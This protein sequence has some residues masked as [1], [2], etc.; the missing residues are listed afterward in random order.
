MPTSSVTNRTLRDQIADVLRQAILFGEFAPGQ[1]LMESELAQ[2]FQVS[3]TPVRE[4]LNSLA[5]AGLVERHGRQGT[6]VR[7]LDISDVENLLSVRESLEV[8][9]VRQAAP[10]VTSE[11]ERRFA[12]ILRQQAEATEQVAANPEGSIPKLVALNDEFHELILVRSNN[13]WLGSMLT[14]IQDLLIFARAGLRAK[15]T[16]TRRRESLREHRRL[17]RALIDGDA[18]TAA[19]VMSEHV[20]RTKEHIISLAT[21]RASGESTREATARTSGGSQASP[22]GEARGGGSAAGHRHRD[23]KG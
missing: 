8:L 22:N 6:R 16:L 18:D 2:R 12:A 20:R 7:S 21:A 19:A 4:A 14:S 13:P 1:R 3:L 11:D 9:A 10:N 23:R 15:A 5:G 17:A